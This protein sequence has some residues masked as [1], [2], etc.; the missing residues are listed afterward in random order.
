MIKNEELGRGDPVVDPWAAAAAAAAATA[1]KCRSKFSLVRVSS[2]RSS[3]LANI[4][5]VVVVVTPWGSI[6]K[7]MRLLIRSSL[8]QM[9]ANAGRKQV[10]TKK[11]YNR[12]TFD[13]GILD[14][15]IIFIL[16]TIRPPSPKI[17]QITTQYYEF[18]I[19]KINSTNNWSSRRL[20]VSS[21]TISNRC[22]WKLKGCIFS[23]DFFIVVLTVFSNFVQ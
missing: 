5:D 17:H 3:L 16:S 15:P 21:F 19:I 23:R 22:V 8:T 12:V 4:A 6:L 20:R 18:L 1:A 2:L 10:W 14:R 9:A 13:T 7:L 11:N